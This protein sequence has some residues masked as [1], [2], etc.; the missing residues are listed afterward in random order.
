MVPKFE[1]GWFGLVVNDQRKIQVVV[2]FKKIKEMQ[3]MQSV[4]LLHLLKSLNFA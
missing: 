4:R 1:S 3:K 2:E